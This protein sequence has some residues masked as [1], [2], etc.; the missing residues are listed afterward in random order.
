MSYSLNL[1]RIKA[2][3]NALGNLQN[4]VIFV[5]GATVALYAD[6]KTEEVRPTDDIDILV[7]IATHK[8]YA[9]VEEQLRKRG[10]E[11]DIESGIICRYK[12]Q[13]IIVD[14]MP[15]NE[16]VLLFSNKW[17]AEGFTNAI[18]YLIDAEHTIKIF[19]AP[20]FIATK[21]EAFKNR[22]KNDGRTST[23]F[24]DIIF[25]FE[26]R[27]SIWGELIVAPPSIKEYLIKEFKELLG[28]LLFEEW[29]DAH[30]G[31]GSPPATYYIIE[32]L[33]EFV[34]EK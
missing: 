10:F 1:L 33:E 7:E 2:V 29:V 17:Y 16:E 24:E 31:F 6:R 3:Y 9:I 12:V 19:S 21:L 18:N 13:G 11:N 22:G 14:I 30:A 4:E 26:N 28:N 23:D 8:D 15:T 32:R 25:V 34:N 20:Y 27:S 5:G